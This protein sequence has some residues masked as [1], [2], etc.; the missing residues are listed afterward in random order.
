MILTI[1]KPHIRERTI[2]Y[3]EAFPS[4]SIIRCNSIYANNKKESEDPLVV[5]LQY[6]L[7][8]EEKEERKK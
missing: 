8:R 3:R 2:F 6:K 5:E 7:D 4:I 1:Y